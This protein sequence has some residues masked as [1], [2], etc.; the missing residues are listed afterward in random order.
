M[1][2]INFKPFIFV[3]KFGPRISNRQRMRK[4]LL[5]LLAACLVSATQVMAE[6]NR[7]PALEAR[8]GA[9][10]YVQSQPY[11]GADP[12]LLPTPVIFFDNRL[13][14]V[15]WTRVGLYVYGK[16]NWGVSITAEPRPWGYQ[17]EDASALRG[18]AER[19]PGWEGGL[20]IGG[21]NRLGF[22]ELTYFH[23]LQDN[24]DGGL[25]R[26]EAGTSFSQGRWL[27]VP[28]LYIIR[29]SDAI[30]DY[31]YGVSP[32]ESTAQRPAYDAQA[33]VNIA[34]QYFFL[35]E[36][37][38]RWNLSANTR[39]D[40]L[41]PEITDSPLVDDRWMASAMVSLLYKMAF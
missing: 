8:I 14:Y 10:P 1:T 32:R 40:Y 29:Y 37:N 12:L 24:S 23:D 2:D 17:A 30:I 9:G 26:L 36:M 16:Q 31:Y 13:L 6:Q 25:L 41:A 19:K 28:S 34:L 11:Q 4:R 35:Y 33:A 20:A 15:R 18:M 7:E 39:V 3:A 5:Y 38:R 22:A 27:H 21:K